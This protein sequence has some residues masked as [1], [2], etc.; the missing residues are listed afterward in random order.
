MTTENDN[1]LSPV[2]YG[3]EDSC[4]AGRAAQLPAAV[5][6]PEVARGPEPGL[7]GADAN[8]DKRIPSFSRDEPPHFTGIDIFLDAP[9]VED[10]R[11]S[12]PRF[13]PGDIKKSF[14]RIPNA[15]GHV[16]ALGAFP[17]VL[18]CLVRAG[19]LPRPPE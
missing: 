12:D 4:A 15:V 18:G 9:H 6:E 1:S 5:W 17:V 3:P 2:D 7:P 13:G 14:D 10:V 8:S 16:Y 19:H 11:T